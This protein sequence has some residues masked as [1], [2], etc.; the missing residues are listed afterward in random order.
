MENLLSG[1]VTSAT[2]I[3]VLVRFFANPEASSYL[4]GL[5]DEFGLSTNSVREELNRLSKAK[6]LT[7]R[8]NG[9]EIHYRANPKHP[10]FNELRSVVQKVLGIDRVVKDI[11]SRLGDLEKAFLVNDYALGRDSGIIDL[12]LVGQVDHDNLLDLVA[13]TEKYIKRKIRTLVLTSKEYDDL[14]GHF[15]GRPSLLLWESGPGPAEPDPQK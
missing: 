8:R 7:S 6:L 12:V 4:R 3:K 15:E 14:A 9:R 11:V 2:R 13:K 10:L 5:A 1:L